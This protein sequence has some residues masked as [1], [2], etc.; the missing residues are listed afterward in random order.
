MNA[1]KFLVLVFITFLLVFSALVRADNECA[2][3]EPDDPCDCDQTGE[4]SGR[5]KM[6][7]ELKCCPKS[8]QAYCYDPP[9]GPAQSIVEVHNTLQGQ[10]NRVTELK[11]RG[12]CLS[13]DKSGPPRGGFPRL[14]G[15]FPTC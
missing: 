8:Q 2:G 5:C 9:G 12:M 11:M 4:C 15:V 3:K 6:E 10:A 1:K 7:C 14:D 13:L